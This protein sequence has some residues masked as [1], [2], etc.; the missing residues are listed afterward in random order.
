MSRTLIT[1]GLVITASDEMTV[2][3]LIE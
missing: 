3:V 2:D 1:G